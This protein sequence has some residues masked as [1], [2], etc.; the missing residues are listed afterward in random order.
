MEKTRTSPSRSGFYFDFDG[1]LS[2]IQIDPATVLPVSGAV[3]SLTRLVGLVH[4][5][6]IVSAR[7]V[8]FLQSR[9]GEVPGVALHGL[10]GLESWESGTATSSPDAERWE[11]VIR[12]LLARAR[13]ELPGEILIEDKRLSMA[14]HYRRAPQCED[15]ALHWG[16]DQARRHGVVL[17][18]GPYTV[19]LKPPV[20]R[21]KGTVLAQAISGLRCVWYFGDGAPDLAAFRALDGWSAGAPHRTAVR[22]AVR[23]PDSDGAL[24]QEADLVLDGPDAVPGL[25]D[26]VCTALDHRP[27]G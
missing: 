1:T 7:P 8:D 19:E 26:A 17:E 24:L 2:R 27:K 6:G 4:A 10:Y 13:A 25:L 18:Q 15:R 5:V 23:H 20:D 11:P 12:A 22:V 16:R 14:L 3:E 9:F 21:D